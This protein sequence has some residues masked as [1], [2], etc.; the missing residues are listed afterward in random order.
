MSVTTEE[1]RELTAAFDRDRKISFRLKEKHAAWCV[2]ST[3]EWNFDKYKYKPCPPRIKGY[4]GIIVTPPP[5]P[6]QTTPLLPTRDEVY[7]YAKVH[8]FYLKAIIR[9]DCEQTENLDF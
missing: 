6:P 4:I 1:I 8:A 5:H 7:Q 2:T 9:V 3:P